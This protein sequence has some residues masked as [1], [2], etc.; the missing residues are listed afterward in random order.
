MKAYSQSR[1]IVGLTLNI[2]T[3]WRLT[4]HSGCRTPLNRRAGG[5]QSQFGHFEGEKSH[6][7]IGI[8]F[9]VHPARNLVAILTAF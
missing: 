8:Q 5:S 7:A 1:L 6:A 2:G 4:S 9:P 3:G